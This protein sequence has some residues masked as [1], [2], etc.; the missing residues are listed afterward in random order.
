[1]KQKQVFT[2]R[3]KARR[4][5]PVIPVLEPPSRIYISLRV[6]AALRE[7]FLILVVLYWSEEKTR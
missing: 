1:L 4:E 2:Q 7:T 6:L 5:K 3:R